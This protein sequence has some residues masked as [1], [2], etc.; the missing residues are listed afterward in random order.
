[1]NRAALPVRLGARLWGWCLRRWVIAP[2]GQLRLAAQILAAGVIGL[3]L[4]L[5]WMAPSMQ[6]DLRA[7]EARVQEAVTGLQAVRQQLAALPQPAG[8]P[9]L[10]SPAEP[11]NPIWPGSQAASITLGSGLQLVHGK[12]LPGEGPVGAAPPS[13]QLQLR[14]PYA[15]HGVWMAALAGQSRPVRLVSWQLQADPSGQHQALALIEPHSGPALAGPDAAAR[16]V[17]SAPAQLDP[18]GDPVPADPMVSLPA[19]WRSELQRQRQW[20]ESAPL[21]ALALSGTLRRASDWVALLQRDGQL[22]TVRVGDYVGPDMGRVERI[23]EQGLW[24]REIVHSGGR[25][26]IRQRHWR[27]GESP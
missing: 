9:A 16:R 2:A 6:Q 8:A 25:W 17:Y 14:G 21:S 18:L 23:D 13:L 15:Q 4:P 12:P 7:A 22:H 3:A 24:L 10:A 26:Q 5:A 19:A 1:M 11:A 20:L 27:V